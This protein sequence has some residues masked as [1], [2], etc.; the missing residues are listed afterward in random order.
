MRTSS[1]FIF[2]NMA[3]MRIFS[4]MFICMGAGFL[5]PESDPASSDGIS[6]FCPVFFLVPGIEKMGREEVV[7]EALGP[8]AD[9]LITQGYRWSGR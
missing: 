9:Y 7:F 2:W 1:S 6:A 8:H 4:F 5:D 3:A